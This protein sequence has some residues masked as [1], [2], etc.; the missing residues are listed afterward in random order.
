MIK[1]KGFLRLKGGSLGETTFVKSVDGYRAQEK[2]NVPAGKFLTDP[3]FE[4][5]RENA[6]EFSRAG[7]AGKTLRFALNILVS[8]AK[9][10]RMTSRLLK[11]IREVMDAD[12]VSPRGKRNLVDGNIRLLERFQFNANSDLQS[13]LHQDF[14]S[15]IDRVTG[16]LTVTMPVLNPLEA[17]KAP[18][19]TT[20]F[21]IVSAGT[22]INFEQATSN[23]DAKVSAKLPWDATPTVAINNVHAVTANSTNILIIAAGIRFY[24]QFN[25]FMKPLNAGKENALSIIQVNKV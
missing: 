3:A 4:S 8:V 20:H 24:K 1:Q 15:T 13:V 12:T 9:D 6:S 19:G 22:E 10:N 5:A 21:E 18:K 16:Q 23:T 17:V 7:T 2:L 11:K 14:G 25:G